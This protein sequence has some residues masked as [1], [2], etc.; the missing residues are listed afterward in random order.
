[1]N[2][3]SKFQ[4]GFYNTARTLVIPLIKLTGYSWEP[5]TPKSENYLVLTNHNTNWDFLYFAV[6][7]KKQMYYVASEHIFRKGLTSKVINALVD[8]IPRRKGAA[9]DDTVNMILERLKGG[10]NVCMMAE[11]NRSFSGETGFVS[12]KTAELVKKSGAGLI[13]LAVHG[14]YFVNPRWA[15]KI[16]FGPTWGA[17]QGEYTAEELAAMSDEEVYE[18][19]KRDIYVDAY[20]DQEKKMAKYRCLKPAEGLETALFYCPECGYLDTMRSHGSMFGCL[21]CGTILKF[22]KYGYFEA[23]AEGANEPKFTTI[24]DWYHAQLDYMKNYVYQ[25][26]YYRTEQPLFYDDNIRLC[27]VHTG[28]GTKLI[29]DGRLVMYRDRMEL[30]N[31]DQTVSFELKDIAKISIALRDTMLFTVGDKYYQIKSFR[32][33]Y[34]A[35]KYVMASRLLLGKEY[36]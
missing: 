5:Y 3:L 21:N 35:L 20:A 15:N 23:A 14:C 33:T 32:G 36:Y 31:D 25:A 19:I 12:P 7:L 16:R 11:G 2:E 10:Y 26:R 24:K 8:P 22:N 17:V 29:A 13:T 9:S 6:V 1:M 28:E 4:K 18:I 27:E 30:V 34:S